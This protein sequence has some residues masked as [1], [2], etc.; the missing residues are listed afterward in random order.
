[1]PA[2]PFTAI[3]VFGA[4]PDHVKVDVLNERP[5]ATLVALM[6]TGL[7]WDY[8]EDSVL[9]RL[10]RG[11]AQT[12]GRVDVYQ[13]AV[14][15]Q[16]DPRTATFAIDRWETLLELSAGDL[17]LVERRLQALAA[18]RARGG[19]TGT[20]F[21]EQLEA[22]GYEGIFI[23]PLGNPFRCGDRLRKR[24]QNTGFRYAFKI[25]AFS[26]PALDAEMIAAVRDG[27]RATVIV[28]FEL[29]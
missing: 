12:F 6:P 10:L 1:M 24:L 15:A 18:L 4:G 22:L 3:G 2:V 26:I 23:E 21:R 27:L 8:S 19:Q 14:I 29:S 25:R 16:L 20:Y 5:M 13:R 28:H 17:T 11:V 9:R 7:A